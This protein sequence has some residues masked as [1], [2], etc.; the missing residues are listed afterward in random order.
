MLMQRC[1]L[2]AHARFVDDTARRTA[3]AFHASLSSAPFSPH[4]LTLGCVLVALLIYNALRWHPT[5]CALLAGAVLVE[6]S[7]LERRAVR[8]GSAVWAVTAALAAALLALPFDAVV[9]LAAAVLARLCVQALH[10]RWL[11][12]TLV[13]EMKAQ[14][15]ALPPPAQQD[16][17]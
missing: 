8:D 5:L 12:R 2:P 16:V 13:G 1:A 11:V 10:A 17:D 6:P 7:L 15:A 14:I 3:T 4:V 9:T